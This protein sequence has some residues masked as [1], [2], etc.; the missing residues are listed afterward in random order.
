MALL[1]PSQPM[2]TLL[3]SPWFEIV[4]RA[5]G[6][7]LLTRTD[8]VFESVVEITARSSACSTCSRVTGSAS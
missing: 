8:R 2:K 4:H 3:T 6:I 1:A 7:V 5:E